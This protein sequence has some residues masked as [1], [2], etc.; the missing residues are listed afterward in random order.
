ML[1]YRRETISI[2]LK[3][4]FFGVPGPLRSFELYTLGPMKLWVMVNG[5]PPATQRG[6]LFHMKKKHIPEPCMVYLTE[7]FTNKNHL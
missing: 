4:L 3:R 1:V 5:S 2:H 7:T 6:F